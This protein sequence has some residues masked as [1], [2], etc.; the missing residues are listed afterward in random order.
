VAII[1]ELMRIEETIGERAKMA[2][3]AL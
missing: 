1:N 2:N 3:L